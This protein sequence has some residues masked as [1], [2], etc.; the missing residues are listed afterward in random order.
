MEDGT[1]ALIMR[2]KRSRC[3]HNQILMHHCLTF[4]KR[5]CRQKRKVYVQPVGRHSADNEE[6]ARLSAKPG[7]RNSFYSSSN[8]IHKLAWSTSIDNFLKNNHFF[9]VINL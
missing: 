2:L 7:S 6:E 9:R 5:W 3:Y 1:A 8:D 4:Q